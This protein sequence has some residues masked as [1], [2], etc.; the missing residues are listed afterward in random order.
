MAQK[1]QPMKGNLREE[2]VLERGYCQNHDAVCKADREE[3][4]L[5]E[6]LEQSA[7]AHKRGDNVYLR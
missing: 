4:T 7:R 1:A 5:L 2:N 3:G 6:A